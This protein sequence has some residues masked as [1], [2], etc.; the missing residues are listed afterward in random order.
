MSNIFQIEDIA[1][2]KYGI[3]HSLN[4]LCKN[5]DVQYAVLMSKDGRML[6]SYTLDAMDAKMFKG[7][8]RGKSHLRYLASEF[9]AGLK[10]SLLQYEDKNIVFSGVGD[11]EVLIALL[12]PESDLTINFKKIN[13]TSKVLQHIIKKKPISDAVLNEYKEDVAQ[14]LKVIAKSIEM[15]V[16]KKT[17]T[18]AEDM[19]IY[20]QLEKKL[21]NYDLPKNI[22]P[23][24]LMEMNLSPGNIG[25]KNWKKVVTNITNNYLFPRLSLEKADKCS[26][27]LMAITEKKDI[28][29][30]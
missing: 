7:L 15:Q 29:F 21:E 26:K 19:R 18:Y 8:E 11:T 24:V 28:E 9:N 20:N 2:I 10:L 16:W 25:R 27:E 5:S 4:R 13:I 14:E 6:S 17:G 3:N 1:L 22:I 23:M 12:N 30:I